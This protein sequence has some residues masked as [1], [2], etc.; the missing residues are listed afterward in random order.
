MA[1]YGTRQAVLL[2]WEDLSGYLVAE[3]FKLSPYNEC[4]A[5]KQIKGSQCTI[6]WHINNMKMSHTSQAVLED[7]MDK[8]NEC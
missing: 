4:M 8:L 6:L 3:A 2:L 1:L 5:N 7:M